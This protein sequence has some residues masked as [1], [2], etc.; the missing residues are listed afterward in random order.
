MCSQI[1]HFPDDAD[2]DQ[3]AA[4]YLLR[5][6]HTHTHTFLNERQMHT[7]VPWHMHTNTHTFSLNYTWCTHTQTH[8]HH[9]RTQH[10]YTHYS[11][12]HT[13]IQKGQKGMVGGHQCTDV[14]FKQSILGY[15]CK[16]VCMSVQ[17]VYVFKCPGAGGWESGGV[18]KAFLFFHRWIERTAFT[19]GLFSAQDSGFTSCLHC[20]SKFGLYSPE[21]FALQGY[22]MFHQCII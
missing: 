10:T 17:I 3:D 2:Y 18:Q 7:D 19:N 1:N 5:E 8:T 22:S 21:P 11:L 16:C 15:L 14:R 20:E 4:E 13:Q 6:L 12:H 9:S